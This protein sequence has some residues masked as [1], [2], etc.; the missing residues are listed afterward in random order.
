[1]PN[2]DDSEFLDLIDDYV[3]KFGHTFSA[4]MVPPER[5]DYLVGEMKKA[6]AGD[7]GPITDEELEVDIPDGAAS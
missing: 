3:E 6:I 5:V 1:M 2:L 4:M 7:R